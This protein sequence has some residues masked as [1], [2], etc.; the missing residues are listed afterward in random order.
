MRHVNRDTCGCNFWFAFSACSLGSMANTAVKAW[1][2]HDHHIYCISHRPVTHFHFHPFTINDDL[3]IRNVLPNNCSQRWRQRHQSDQRYYST[4]VSPYFE[5]VMDVQTCTQTLTWLCN[6]MLT[7][8]APHTP[9]KISKQLRNQR[10]RKLW[11]REI[12]SDTSLAGTWC[13]MHRIGQL[14]CI[15]NVRWIVDWTSC[16]VYQW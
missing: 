10:V 8:D 1:F 15:E 16:L 4:P 3:C 14:G 2:I 11:S 5:T 7:V 13:Y 6:M 12:L 9:L